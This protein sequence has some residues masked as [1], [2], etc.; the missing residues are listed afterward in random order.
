[1]NTLLAQLTSEQLTS[2]KVIDDAFAASQYTRDSIDALW[3]KV[4]TGELF[5]GISQSGALIAALFVTW[6]VVLWVKKNVT[7]EYAVGPDSYGPLLVAVFLFFL[8]FSTRPA[9][10]NILGKSWIGASEFGNYVAEVSVRG[11]SKTRPDNELLIAQKKQAVNNRASGDLERCLKLPVGDTRDDC[12]N[13][14]AERVSKE[15]RP[16]FDQTWA[17]RLN[18]FWQNTFEDSTQF[19]PFTRPIGINNEQA[20]LGLGVFLRSGVSKAIVSFLWLVTAGFLQ[21]LEYFKIMTALVSPIF[22]G[23]SFLS[24]DSNLPILK[25]LKGFLTL[26]L[27]GIVFRVLLG[28][29]YVLIVEAP[30]QD[31]LIVPLLLSFFGIPFAIVLASSGGS[32]FFGVALGAIAILRR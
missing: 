25:I 9:Q 14:S 2:N 17:S 10:S 20:K 11:L 32:G 15:L 28:L 18:E 31:P 1:M 5:W 24:L 12:L 26:V 21:A 3:P 22:I 4:L 6:W 16:Y 23:L 13:E 29:V 19:P 27:I 30:P 8:L 7:S